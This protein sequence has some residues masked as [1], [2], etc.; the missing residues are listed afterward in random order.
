MEE[1][2]AGGGEPD[3]LDFVHAASTEA[4]VDGV[5]LAVDGQQWFALAAGL[6]RDQLSG[7]DQAFFVGEA[8]RLAGFDG[9]I[10]GFEAGDSDDG[11]DYEIDFGMGRDAD[12]ALG[13]MDD[14]NLG[15]AGSLETGVEGLRGGLVG[16]RND[17]RLPVERLLINSVGVVAGGEGRDLE[18]IG[19]A[20]DDAESAA[21]DGA[22]RT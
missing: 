19:I 4:L 2:A 15:Q 5:V 12:R 6:G 1:R 14:L 9:F 11:T 21:A 22:G 10:G 18:A 13:A 3:A 20:F 8:D 7:N 16:H 17:A